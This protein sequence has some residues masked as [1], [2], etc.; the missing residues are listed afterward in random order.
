LFASK[1]AS[2]GKENAANLQRLAAF[3]LVERHQDILKKTVTATPAQAG[4]QALQTCRIAA[5]AAMTAF[6]D[7]PQAMPNL[8]SSAIRRRF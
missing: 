1:L 8:A 6:S 5:C 2:T 7:L 4:A 3:L